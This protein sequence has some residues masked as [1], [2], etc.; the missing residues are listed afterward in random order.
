MALRD[1]SAGEWLLW[2]DAGDVFFTNGSASPSEFVKR[3]RLGWPRACHF[4]YDHGSLNA[5]VYLI[6]RSCEGARLLDAHPGFSPR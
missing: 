5:G 4:V 1:A 2:I 6:Q 3:A